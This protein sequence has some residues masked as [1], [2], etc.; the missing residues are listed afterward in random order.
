MF[1]LATS[2]FFFERMNEQHSTIV[3]N[4][5]IVNENITTLNTTYHRPKQFILS[6][7]NTLRS[8][9]F[10]IEYSKKNSP[11]WLKSAVVDFVERN[12]KNYETF[13]H[14]RNVSAH[15]KLIFPAESLVGGLFRIRSQTH[16]LLKL[17]LGDH[18]GPR[19]YAPDMALKNTEDIF[20]DL[21]TFSSVVFMD[22]EHSSFGE[23]LG[24]T[25]KWFYKVN[26]KY[27]NEKINEIVDAYDLA[28]TFSS[29]LLDELCYSYGTQKG[30]RYDTPFSRKLAEHNNINTLLELDLYPSLFKIWWEEDIT[31]LNYGIQADLLNGR[32]HNA[33]DEY[34]SWIF[35]NLTTNSDEYRTKLPK[36]AK[37]DPDLIF[38]DE[39]IMD[40]LSFIINNHWHFKRAYLVDFTKSPVSPA[41]IM[42]PQRIGKILI[43]EYQT[44]K[45]C[46]ISSAKTQ[47]NDHI[48]KMLAALTNK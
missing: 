48:G 14:L 36:F 23:C 41:E 34:Y 9:L 40:F 22:L 5:D 39:H 42:K 28:T 46:T 38:S 44:K 35:K 15:Q 20:S 6:L 30:L 8:L 21:L 25:R 11:P 19:A 45:A 4:I 43:A 33:S 24:V 18:N 47:L 17:G 1:D 29:L 27:D 12:K 13:K 10:F 31:P 2:S 7:N 32:Q 16:Y 3:Q 37:L 26:L